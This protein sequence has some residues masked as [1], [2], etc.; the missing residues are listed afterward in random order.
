MVSV[1]AKEEEYKHVELF[2]RPALFTNS[3]IDRG[4]VPEGFHCYD[5]RGS[6]RDP[7]KPTT[8]ENRVAVNHAGTVL[9]AEPI[10]IPREGFR[11]LRGGLN[12][13]GECLTLPEF[14]EKQNLRLPPDDRKFILRPASSSEAGL[15]FALPKGR[16]AELGTIGHMRI[17]FGGEGK[18]F[19]HTWWPRGDEEL[20]S[21]E[22]KAELKELVNELKETGPLKS[23]SAMSGYCAGYGGQIEGGGRQDYGY[24][25][26]T[27]HYCY[28][29]RCNPGPGDY[30]AYLAA[31]DL[32]VQQRMNMKQKTPAQDCGLEDGIEDQTPEQGITM[33]GL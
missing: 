3:R 12:F 27:E 1:N 25:V 31:F 28:C 23:L 22:F 18:E 17:D 21:P 9:T 11:R 7:G 30:Q 32:R 20:N 24:I 5:L 2:G 10:T 13:L 29:L 33:G 16:D 8:V 26:E 15:F 19:W 4:T 14:C 6:D